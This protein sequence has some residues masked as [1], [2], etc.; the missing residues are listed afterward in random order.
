MVRTPRVPRPPPEWAT[1]ICHFNS[2]SACY[3]SRKASFADI[4][5]RQVVTS[6]KGLAS[7]TGGHPSRRPTLGGSGLG[8]GE[9]W[10]VGVN[11]VGDGTER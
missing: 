6:S 2:I 5:R 11:P 4:L 3:V 1:N 10:V 9:G 8:G 7:M